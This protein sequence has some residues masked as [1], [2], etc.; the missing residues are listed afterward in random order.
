[1]RSTQVPRLLNGAMAR[2]WLTAP[3]LRTPS[4]AAGYR[5]RAS[6]SFPAAATTNAPSARASAMA[7]PSSPDIWFPLSTNDR[8]ITSAPLLAAQRIPSAISRVDPLPLVI[9]RTSS[10]STFQ[11]KPAV[12]TALSL[13]APINPAIKVPWLVSFTAVGPSP[14]PG[15]RRTLPLKSG[16]KSSMPVSTIAIVISGSPVL[17]SQA[18]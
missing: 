15:T 9:T 13:T 16:C 2:A 14:H 4:P 1:M 6:P 10:R 8:V 7:S 3:T 11:S 5:L 18:E 17:T 12:P